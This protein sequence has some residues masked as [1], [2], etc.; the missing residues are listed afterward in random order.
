MIRAIFHNLTPELMAKMADRHGIVPLGPEPWKKCF[1]G[2]SDDH[3]GMHVGTAHTVT[4]YA[5]DVAE[6]LAH[7]R[8]GQHEPAGGCGGSIMMGHS[9]YHIAY[10]YYKDRFLRNNDKPTILGELFKKLLE[11]AER[12][13]EPAGLG[14]RLRGLAVGMVHRRRM[15]QASELEQTLVKDLSELFSMAE[16]RE[17]SLQK[18]DDRHT[19]H[20]AC[21]V[22]HALGYSFLQRFVELIRQ[23][24]LLESLQTVAALGPVALSM[25]PYLA[26]FGA[27]H[28]DE[29]FLNAVAA[30]FAPIAPAVQATVR[31][32]WITDTYAEVNGVS[33]T[34]QAMAVAARKLRRPLTVLTCAQEVP[35]AEADVKNFAPV[36][37]FSLPEYESQPLAF[38][39][40]LEVIEYIERHRFTE[41]IISTPGP[42]GLTGLAAARLLGLRTIGIYHTDFIE[43]VRHLTQDD[44]LA[45]LAGKYMFWFYDQAQTILV[46]TQCY[47]QQLIHNGFDPA[48]LRVMT[49]GIDSR[50]FR[51]DRRDPSFFDRWGLD[52]SLKFLYVG[53]I[54]REK[55]L[56][57]L[58]DAFDQF[59]ARGHAAQLV[60]VG[61][62]P[63]RKELQASCRGRP[64]TFTGLLEGDK[65][66]TAFAS[67]DVMVFPSTTD[68]FGNVVLEAQA[69][70]LP[71]IVSDLGGPAEIVRSDDSGIIVDHLQPQALA[72]AM[73]KLYLSPEIRADLRA[74]G[75]RNTAE[76]TWE[77]A[78]ESL[79]SLGGDTAGLDVAAFRSPSD[80][81]ARGAI[82]LEI[83]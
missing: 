31:K 10:S 3:S 49:R 25:A 71:M 68:T 24:R 33:R 74:R 76:L 77:N 43:Y 40:F 34:I 19:F 47:R 6:F 21:Q 67:A 2:G 39:P 58:V 48:K 62:G 38:P 51:P 8:R 59:R 64:I 23:G 12:P 17:S 27:Q 70:G 20:L 65:L 9:V 32:A 36:G 79:W 63:Y 60:I 4:P 50:H 61:D 26:A 16:R 7:L 22:G 69:S 82:A 83:A 56:D 57:R 35:P 55:G 54:S 73:E 37:M 44:D 5:S 14:S 41:L 30:H 78:L 45:D 53:R 81:L 1:T 66:A 52:A 72:D 46:P 42:L 11:R 15:R 80:R 18:M 28:K 29:A 75:L 13:P